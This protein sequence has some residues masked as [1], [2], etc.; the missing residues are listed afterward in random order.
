MNT[1]NNLT[2]SDYKNFPKSREVSNPLDSSKKFKESVTMRKNKLLKNRLKT[3]ILAKGISEP[4]FFHSLDM[5]RQQ[6]YYLSWGIVEALPHLKIR[7]AEALGCDTSVIF[8]EVE[9][10][11][12]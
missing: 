7:I 6:W 3:L 10:G 12:D 1:D 8:K 9:D 2:Q 4:E 5:S 11:A